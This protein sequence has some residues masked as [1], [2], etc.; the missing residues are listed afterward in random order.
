MQII[1]PDIIN[2]FLACSKNILD[3]IP[4]AKLQKKN[5]E[6]Y[7]NLGEYV[8]GKGSIAPENGSKHAII[9]ISENP[10]NNSFLRIRTTTEIPKRISAIMIKMDD[11]SK[12]FE[13]QTS[14]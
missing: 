11:G 4:T 1:N 6:T 2:G 10:I 5:D 7:P 8:P 12:K 3:V 13:I 9:T 14:L